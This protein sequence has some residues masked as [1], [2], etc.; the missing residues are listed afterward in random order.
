MLVFSLVIKPFHSLQ[1]VKLTLPGVGVVSA[2]TPIRGSITSS[3][4]GAAPPQSPSTGQSPY[5]SLNVS[6]DSQQQP[7]QPKEITPIIATKYI[8]WCW[9]RFGEFFF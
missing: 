5:T 6:K 4:P 3:S 9:D 8:E 1:K 7:Q 2:G